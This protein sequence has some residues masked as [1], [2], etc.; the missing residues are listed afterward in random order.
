MILAL[1]VGIYVALML[2]YVAHTNLGFS[3]DQIRGA[4]IAATIPIAGLLAMDYLRKALR[5]VKVKR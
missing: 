1:G 4:A 2:E 3:Q 5:K